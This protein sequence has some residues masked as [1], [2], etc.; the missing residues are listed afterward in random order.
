MEWPR[1]ITPG[2]LILNVTQPC[3]LAGQGDVDTRRGR[4]ALEHITAFGDEIGAGRLAFDRRG[5]GDAG[6]L[7]AVAMNIGAVVRQ[8]IDLDRAVVLA[9]VYLAGGDRRRQLDWRG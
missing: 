1:V 9:A 5:D 3:A 4:V 8:P 7:Q 2:P 6:L